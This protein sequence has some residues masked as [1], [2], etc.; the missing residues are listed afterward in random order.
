MTR[1]TMSPAL[2]DVSDD[3]SLLRTTFALFPSGIVMLSALID[4]VPV[5]LVASSFQVGISADPPLV[6]FAVQHT[7]TTWPTL[8]RAPRLGVSVLGGL[9]RSAVGR[10]SAK[11]GD[12][13]AGIDT[14]TSET[15]AHFVGGAA[16]HLECSIHAEIRAGDHDVVLMEVHRM[17]SDPSTE[18]LVWHGSTLR[19]LTPPEPTH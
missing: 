10:M 12:R 2:V 5:G 9:H 14:F 16:A 13:F 8:R 7:S 17:G 15:G 4:D 1:T 11:S 19:S 6:L 18:P 3:A